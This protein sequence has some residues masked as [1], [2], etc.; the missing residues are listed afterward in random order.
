L[1]MSLANLDIYVNLAGGLKLIDPGLDLAIALAVYSAVMGKPVP[2][3]TAVFGEVGLA[4]EVRTVSQ[5]SRRISEAQ[6]IG[7]KRLVTPPDPHAKSST[8]PGVKSVR[9]AVQAVW[10]KA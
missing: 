3:D 6:R 5:L 7:F 10:G 1:D 4:G 2:D 9:E 8:I